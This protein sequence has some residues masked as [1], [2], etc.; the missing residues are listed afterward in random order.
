MSGGD[1]S[2]AATPLPCSCS[3]SHFPF[4]AF[5]LESF[6]STDLIQLTPNPNQSYTIQRGN[7]QGDNDV[8]VSVFIITWAREESNTYYEGGVGDVCIHEQYWTLT[9][10]LQMKGGGG[11]YLQIQREIPLS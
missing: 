6:V 9:Q 3:K 4:T 10:K 5:I 8:Q 2:P 11:V 7:K 1:A